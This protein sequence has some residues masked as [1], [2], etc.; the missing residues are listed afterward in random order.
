MSISLNTGN[1]R[2]YKDVATLLLKYGPRDELKAAFEDPAFG[3]EAFAA[4]EVERSEDARE[5][6][7]DLEKRGP[8][9]VKIGQLLSTRSDLLPPA[10]LAALQRLQDDVEPF[11]F[12]EVRK[13]VEEHLGV[14][15]SSA[16]ESFDEKPLAA[17]SLGQV[18]RAVLRNGKMEVAV[19][20]QRPGIRKRLLEDLEG[21]AKMAE[22]LEK[23]SETAKRHR[24]ASI[25][26]E[27][28]KRITSE[29][30]YGRESRNLVRLARNLR[31]F[32]G[33]VVPA[34][35]PD[36]CGSQVLTMELLDGT[37]VT[38][39]SGV[40]RVELDGAALTDE[41][42]KAY[43]Q[44]VLVDG[45]FHADPHP[46]NVLLTRDHKVGLIDLGMVGHVP[47]GLRNHLLA[48][49][50]ALSK[51]HGEECAN[52][53][54]KIGRANDDFDPKEFRSAI[55]EL[56][57]ARAGKCVEDMQVGTA[58]MEITELCGRHGLVIPH[59]LYMLGK[60]LLNLDM[61]G[62]ALDPE[63]R[64]DE[65]IRRHAAELAERRLKATLTSGS[66]LSLAVEAKELLARTPER[67]NEV[68]R[69]LS[70]NEI[71]VH[72][73]AIDERRLLKGI[74]KIANRITMGL[75]LGALIVGAAMM[76]HIDA[77]FTILGYP[78]IAMFFFLVAS[79]GALVLAARILFERRS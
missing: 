13:S 5:F 60:M 55:S 74:E 46:G 7:R 17:A 15:L 59:E 54:M 32:P 48:L 37:R 29:L 21:L 25:V 33:I 1:L 35:V 67:I 14:R 4:D 8:T 20:V 34:P 72:V 61:I 63:F 6:A 28:R 36:Y 42:F 3:S 50:L 9:F 53:A 68:L 71:E 75:I 43:L 12:K 11:G 44:Q 58:V 66:L 39:L 45:F 64:P 78:G 70:N 69:K 2:I 51:S 19:K 30:D 18:H 73:D 22:F 40:V 79:T 76:M 52:L 77:N 41:L 38:D 65:A 56:V 47:E 26:D 23:H 57:A 27:V 31:E 24:F 16:F 10:W 49:L 62:Q